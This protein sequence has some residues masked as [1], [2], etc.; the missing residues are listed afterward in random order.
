VALEPVEA[1]AQHRLPPRIFPAPG[2]Y[3]GREL[4]AEVIAAVVVL[5]TVMRAKDIHRELNIRATPTTEALRNKQVGHRSDDC[6][7]ARDNVDV[8]IEE[9]VNSSK[10]NCYY[11]TS[12]RCLQ[13]SVIAVI[14][15]KVTE[16]LSRRH[17]EITKTANK[18]IIKFVVLK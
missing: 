9:R 13:L 7:E 10:I 18:Y 5:A 2:G 14:I 8:G 11:A 1:L 15:L 12:L 6:R 16:K 17:S 4:T 3:G